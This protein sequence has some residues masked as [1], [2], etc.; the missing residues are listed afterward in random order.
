M[1]WLLLLITGTACLAG[2]AAPLPEIKTGT[3]PEPIEIWETPWYSGFISTSMAFLVGEVGDAT[4]EIQTSPQQTVMWERCDLRVESAFGQLEGIQGI[5]E[6]KLICSQEGSPYVAVDPEWGRIRHLKKGQR[7][8]LLLHEHEGPSFGYEA[9]IELTEATRALPDMLRRTACMPSQFT[10]EDLVV[11]EAASPLLHDQLVEERA[12]WREA[13]EEE[14]PERSLAAYALTGAAS[15][16]GV[17][18]LSRMWRR[19]RQHRLRQ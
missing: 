18:A 5:K 12:H 9:I 11:V 2:P 7:I 4:S 8:L 17:L 14:T 1:R 16:A 19:S 15:T 3:H 6:A 13:Y 10:D